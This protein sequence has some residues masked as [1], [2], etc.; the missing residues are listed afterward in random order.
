MLSNGSA[1][2]L[3]GATGLVGGHLLEHLLAAR[4]ER[5]VLLLIRQS[6]K[7]PLFGRNARVIPLKG[8]VTLPGLGLD[9]AVTSA[10]ESNLTEIIHCAADTRFGLPLEQARMTNTVGTQNLLT[11][12]A[13]C[14]RI[15]KFAHLSTVY[16][17]GRSTGRVMETPL[18]H[19]SGFCN[20]Y[21]QSKYEAEELLV[22]AM[23]WLPVTIF[24]LS[25]IIGDSDTG[26]VR[27]FNY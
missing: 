24:R 13:H 22:E 21:Q 19:S 20:T 27:Q 8:D 16:V 14:K 10:L 4:P 17:A 3:T 7:A 1:L 6:D 9:A 12:A 23:S 2:L 11:L 15:K 18:K 5:Q 25:S 26:R